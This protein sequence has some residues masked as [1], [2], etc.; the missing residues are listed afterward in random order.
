MFSG[1]KGGMMSDKVELF[2]NDVKV[3]SVGGTAIPPVGYICSICGTSFPTQTSLASHVAYAHP[4][5][6]PI[7]GTGT[8][9]AQVK[10]ALRLNRAVGTLGYCPELKGV[11]D[12]IGVGENGK[13]IL[14]KG[15]LIYFYFGGESTMTNPFVVNVVDYTQGESGLLS[16]KLYTL[17]VEDNLMKVVRPKINPLGLALSNNQV[18]YAYQWHEPSRRYLLEIDTRELNKDLSGVLISRA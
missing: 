14:Y 4:V 2:I 1:K 12:K 8:Y 6:P 9:S 11:G 10:E 3:F 15:H 16:A 17:D 7:P 18:S 5:T 13:C